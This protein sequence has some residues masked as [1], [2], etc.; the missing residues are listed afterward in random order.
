MP[1]P[2]DRSF[3]MTKAFGLLLAALLMQ[4]F[5][6]AEKPDSPSLPTAT[7]T[8]IRLKMADPALG[9]PGIYLAWSYPDDAEAS[10]YEIYQSLSKDSL[11]HSAHQ[12]SAADSMAV[13]LPLP[14][15]SRPFTLYYAVRA[16]LIEATGQKLVG[17]T[18]EIDSITIAPSLSILQPGAGSYK[19]GRVLNMEVQTSS[20]IG[21][22]LRIAYYEKSG[23]TWS[24]KQD[25]CLP[26]N[27]CGTT[28]FGN[29]LQ[30][31]SLTLEQHPVT[32]TIPALFCVIGTESF[33]EQ[34][35]GQIQSLGC[36]RFFRIAP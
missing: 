15:L 27:S 2:V 4:G 11:R 19:G 34:R 32:D 28:L 6:C 22:N 23:Q 29:S 30:R 14:D 17:D 26:V 16:I 36:T 7:F 25:T 20:D 31:D 24:A 35:T 8:D 18:L 1:T 5:Y 10:Y 12:Q 3:Q 21:V 13:V 33:Q 9:S